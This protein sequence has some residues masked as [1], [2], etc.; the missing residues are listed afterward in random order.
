MTTSPE[1]ISSGQSPGMLRPG[2]PWMSWLLLIG[3]GIFAFRPIS[4]TWDTNANY[5]YGW[6]IPAVCAFLFFERWPARPSRE[7]A[8]LGVGLAPLAI[9]WGI[10][11]FTFRLA[12]ESDPDWRP[13]LWVLAGLYL[14]ALLG[15]L[16][17]YG[18]SAW[19]RHFA[20]PVCFLILSL[21]WLF[22]IEQPLVDGLMHWNASLTA[23]TLRLLAISAIAEG[24]IIRLADGQLGVEEACSGILSLQSSV[25]LGFLLGEI[26]RLSLGRRILLV[27]LTMG[28]ALVGNYGRT[29]FLAL[30]ASAY[31][32]NAVTAWH[33]T[34]GYSI[35][36]FTGAGSWLLCFAFRGRPVSRTRPAASKKTERNFPERWRPAQWM[37]VSVFAAAVLAETGTQAWFGWRESQIPRHPAWMANLPRTGNFKPEAL[38]KT[39]REI[40]FCDAYQAGSWRD[41]RNWNWNAFW[42]F[43]NPKPSNKIVLGWHN[44]DNCLPSVGLTKD[45]DYPNFTADLNGFNLRVQP[46]QFSARDKTIYLFW[47]VY[48]LSG[49]LPPEIENNS[50]AP[51]ASKFRTHLTDVWHG[52]RGV[53]VETLEMALTGPSNYDDAK[54]AYLE[55]LKDLVVPFSLRETR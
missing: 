1:T 42:I 26:Y 52:Y 34:A 55:R 3:A 9:L 25:M 13:G 33:D 11:F 8:D 47:V 37:A 31:G 44:P 16:W 21:P 28:L 41:A 24:N 22:A 23:G 39:T 32:D 4:V 29:L 40:L 17:L 27:L 38:A 46:K 19:V 2:P 12:A 5:S 36:V 53:G 18:G 7:P 14:V 35:L 30:L 51:F 20:F 49:E 15:W 45:R 50:S 10:I 48:P 6:W 43:Y 54:E